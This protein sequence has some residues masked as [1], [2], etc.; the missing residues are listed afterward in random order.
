MGDRGRSLAIQIVDHHPCSA[1]GHPDRD[2]PT[3]AVPGTGHDDPF[4]LKTVCHEESLPGIVVIDHFKSGGLRG[5]TGEPTF[6]C[7]LFAGRAAVT[8]RVP[9]AARGPSPRV[10]PAIPGPPSR[11]RCRTGRCC[12]SC[13]GPGPWQ[14]IALTVAAPLS[15][16][17][18]RGPGR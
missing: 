13:H 12:R 16:A 9:A 8:P 7:E 10:K 6:S 4:A 3:D 14:V 17:A 15:C 11:L 2:G 5:S 1:G 18:R